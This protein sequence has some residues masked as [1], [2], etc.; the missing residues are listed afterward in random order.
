MNKINLIC[1]EHGKKLIV[2]DKKYVCPLGCKFPIKG[3]IPRFVPLENYCSSFG[4]QWQRYNLIQ[5]DSYNHTTISYDRLKRLFGGSFKGL[6]N[7]KVLEVAC[8]AGRFTEIL[9]QNK[10]QVFA[11]DMSR[12]VEANY[13][14]FKNNP[15]Y[16][17]IQGNVMALPL[18]PG[19]F[20]VVV[21]VG[22]VQ[23]T[24]DPEE[25]MKV[26][27]S[28]L[29]HGGLLVM[30][31]YT[32]GYATTFS[33]RVLRN[34]LLKKPAEFSLQFNEK[35][36]NFLWP[37]HRFFF[38]VKKYPVLGSLRR[39][40]IQLSPVVDY[41]DAYPQLG[42]KLLRLS[43]ILDT[44]DTLTDHYKHLRSVEQIKEHLKKLGMKKIEAYYDGNGVEAR[45][46]K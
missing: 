30:D 31:H 7:K 38:K 4:L 14:H 8:G 28:Y 22:C 36:V 41:Y 10:A 25:T 46:I 24:P 1:P 17:I 29:N 43:A 18:K 11:F 27:C 3:N 40:L 2:I 5:L 19:A 44:H 13:S 23:H 21:A 20:D 37:L 9:L 6:K 42:E 39:F 16:Q 32:Y 12:A 33:R 35:M 34:Y 26:L 45:A 15:C